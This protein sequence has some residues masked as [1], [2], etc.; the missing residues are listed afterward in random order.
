MCAT[1]GPNV[2]S[3]VIN[4]PSQYPNQAIPLFEFTA[5]TSIDTNAK[6]KLMKVS[7]AELLKCHEPCESSRSFS[8]MYGVLAAS[9]FGEIQNSEQNTRT[10][11]RL[12]GYAREA[13]EVS[14]VR[15][16]LA[17]CFVSRRN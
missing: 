16:Y 12:E 15:V 5:D 9:I 13:R 6:T 10:W 2:V 4:F 7:I 8:Q 17:R 1:S 11:A 3:L 14:R